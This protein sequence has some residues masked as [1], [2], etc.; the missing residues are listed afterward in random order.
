M[1]P[2]LFRPFFLPSILVVTT[3]GQAGSGSCLQTQDL[4]YNTEPYREQYAWVCCDN[5]HW[6][7]PSGFQDRDDVDFWGQLEADPRST[8]GGEFTFYDAQCGI[9]LYIAPRGRS[10]EEWKEES[11]H[12]GWPSF[13]EEERVLENL[14]E[15]NGGEMVSTCGTHLG[16]DIPD[17]RT[18][19]CINLI[20][21][22]GVSSG[23]STWNIAPGATDEPVESLARARVGIK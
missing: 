7:E 22:A 4:L 6:A 5:H 21:I 10:F 18:R 12:H 14:R 19:D 11:R 16:H 8:N 1:A 3:S 23:S 13:R 17:G 2:L 15:V 9:P 20:C